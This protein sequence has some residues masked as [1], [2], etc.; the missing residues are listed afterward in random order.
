MS[1]DRESSQRAL[2]DFVSTELL[3]DRPEFELQADDDLLSSGLVD[4]LGVMRLIRFVEQHHQIKVP[5]ADVTIEHFLSVATILTY[6]EALVAASDE[7]RS[8]S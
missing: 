2:L 6:L 8:N 7:R 1:W 5:P 4:S 3:T